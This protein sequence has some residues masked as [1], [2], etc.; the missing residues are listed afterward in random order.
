[1]D[2]L[3]S[4]AGIA[5]PTLAWW[6]L[7]DGHAVTIVEKAPAFRAGGYVID[8]WG[9]GYDLA[10]RMGLMLRLEQVGYHVKD[11]RFLGE[12]GRTTGGFGVSALNH[13]THGRFI[14]VPRGELSRALFE[15]IEG[16]VET[17][18]A[19]DVAAIDQR[20]DGVGVRLA[21]GAERTFALVVGADG[22]HSRTRE[23]VFGPEARFERFLGY[24]L[25]AFTIA[26]YPRRDPDEY[27]MYGEPGRL[28]ARFTLHG[29][30][31]LV[32]LVWREPH[33]TPI[34]PDEAGQMALLR[35]RY[36]GAGWEVPAFLERLED[37]ND[38]YLD[39]VSQIRM[40]RWHEGRVTLLGDAAYA[41]SFLAGHGSAL[42]LIGGYVLAGELKRAASDIPA[43][44]A[45]YQRRLFGFM[46]A[47]Q[48]AAIGMAPAFVPKTAFGLG[49]RALAARL[50][51]IGW[52]ADL[53]IGRSLRDQI[54][55]PDYG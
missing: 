35:E 9:K 14:T 32:L 45:A 2:V 43:A 19:D 27:L 44:L 20:P 48:D 30:A 34:P 39:R 4:G 50:L 18:F 5:G 55:L 40:Q 52:L 42:A 24:D 46:R 47:K 6:L 10:D 54:E 12:G 41:P 29:G 28:A 51:G 23:L 16:R 26:G 22:I 38:L 13:T 49:V 7:R 25:A 21:N 11:V 33:G 1:M 36:A 17:I 37:S 15:A 3:I 8:F 53:L 31:S